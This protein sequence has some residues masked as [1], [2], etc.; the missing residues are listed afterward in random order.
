MNK[1]Y[2]ILGLVMGANFEAI[3]VLMGV[4]YLSQWLNE[5]YPQDFVWEKPLYGLAVVVIA[6]SWFRLFK[7]LVKSSQAGDQTDRSDPPSKEP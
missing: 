5:S 3:A 6:V 7:L 2:K 4:R 1:N